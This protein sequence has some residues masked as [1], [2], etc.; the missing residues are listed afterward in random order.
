M[1]ELPTSTVAQG[2]TICS[3]CRQ[4]TMSQCCVIV[5]RVTPCSHIWCVHDQWRSQDFSNGSAQTNK[6]RAER[7]HWL[8]NQADGG[9]LSTL[10]TPLGIYTTD[11]RHAGI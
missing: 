3:P 5:N 2:I 6:W 9:A 4:L 11:N 1:A 8:E 10:S 7:T